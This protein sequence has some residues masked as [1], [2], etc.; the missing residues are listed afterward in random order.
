[1][2]KNDLFDKLLD[3]IDE[4][5]RSFEEL[6]SIDLDEYESL[7]E[8]EQ[9]YLVSKLENIDLSFLKDLK[10]EIE[11]METNS[12]DWD[13]DHEGRKQIMVCLQYQYK[14]EDDDIVTYE[15]TIDG[16]GISDTIDI[17]KEYLI[18]ELNKGKEIND[19]IPSEI[20]CNSF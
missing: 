8:E 19:I 20:E 4:I 12:E 1:M 13:F 17:S 15:Y 5:Y 7:T 11:E 10:T 3:P 2:M 16:S 14:S 9:E 18:E 6:C